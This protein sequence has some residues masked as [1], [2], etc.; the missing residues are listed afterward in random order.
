MGPVDIGAITKRFRE[1]KTRNLGDRWLRRYY[2]EALIN[3]GLVFT[4]K[5]PI[6]RRRTLYS[7]EEK[8]NVTNPLGTQDTQPL[9]Y[10]NSEEESGKVEY[11][12]KLVT[13]KEQKKY[14][15][16]PGIGEPWEIKRQK[17]HEDTQE[18]QV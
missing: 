6:D 16:P 12:A 10:I 4:S 17:D 7:I 5:D 13:T 9:G 18:S 11:K 15:D 1:V 2:L 14:S 8:N 3:C